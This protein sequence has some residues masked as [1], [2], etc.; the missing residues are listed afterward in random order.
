MLEALFNEEIGI[1]T[2]SQSDQ[3]ES[4]RLVFHHLEGAG[5]NRTGAAKQ[6]D[7]LHVLAESGGGSTPAAR[8]RAST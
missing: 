6:D 1:A 7:A 4:V 3:Q 5:A 8:T 2:G